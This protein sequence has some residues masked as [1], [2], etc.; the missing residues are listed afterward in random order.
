MKFFSIC[1]WQVSIRH[2]VGW[3]QSRDPY[4]TLWLTLPN[5]RLVWARPRR[6]D[7]SL[8]YGKQNS[9]YSIPI[10]PDYF[11]RQPVERSFRV[12]MAM[13]PLLYHRGV[14]NRPF[15]EDH[16]G[17]SIVFAGDFDP[18]E[19]SQSPMMEMFGCLPRLAMA[20]ELRD[21]LPAICQFP[22]SMSEYQGINNWKGVIY[23]NR[24]HFAIPMDV[25]REEFARHCFF[26]PTPVSPCHCAT[27]L[28]KRSRLGVFRFCSADTPTRFIRVSVTGGTASYLRANKT[29][30]QLCWRRFHGALSVWLRWCRNV[31]ALYSEF[32]TPKAVVGE[33]FARRDSLQLVYLQAEHDSVELLKQ[34]LIAR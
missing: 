26:W 1:G 12:P 31:L 25:L 34:S 11:T 21:T 17:P 23:V 16:R 28:W 27:T 9:E 29:F 18:K 7:L 4:S 32:F 24:K 6:A 8:C 33:L 3:L 22:R 30:A 13:H 5:V 2:R 20:S 14:W 19:Y 15:P 10:S